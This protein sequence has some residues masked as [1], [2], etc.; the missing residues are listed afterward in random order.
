MVSFQWNGQKIVMT[1]EEAKVS[2]LE[3]LDVIKKSMTKQ[4]DILKDLN[5]NLD[6][7]VKN[8]YNTRNTK[9]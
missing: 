4:A 8:V 1:N 6:K 2:F 5:K 7:N 9:E 3:I